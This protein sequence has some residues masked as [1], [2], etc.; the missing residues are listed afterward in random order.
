[1]Y[2]RSPTSATSAQVK[3]KHFIGYHKSLTPCFSN[4]YRPHNIH[5]CSPYTPFS[6]HFLAQDLIS[7]IQLQ[8][9]LHTITDGIIRTR[10]VIMKRPF[11]LSLEHNLMHRS[12]YL[13]CDH[14]FEEL[15]GVAG[16][17]RDLSFGAETVIDSDEDHGLRGRGGGSSGGGFL[18]FGFAGVARFA[19]AGM[20]ASAAVAVAVAA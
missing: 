7:S 9:N 4:F 6:P 10:K 2:T 20:G 12:A 14:G 13:G 19:V 1:M 15:D 17:A 5:P 16:E 3:N 8:V 11:P 18:V